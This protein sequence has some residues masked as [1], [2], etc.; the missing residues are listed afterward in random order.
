MQRD[1]Y[2]WNLHPALLYG[3][4]LLSG[5]YFA[6]YSPWALLP[7]LLL[8]TTAPSRWPSLTLCFILPLPWL[9]WS[10]AP[11]QGRLHV[12][13]VTYQQG[14]LYRGTLGQRPVILRS[15]VHHPASCDY[16][17][18][19]KW[20]SPS[21][22]EAEEW[23]PLGRPSLAEKRYRI[24][25]VITEWF[26]AHSRDP[27][28]ARFL[29]SLATGGMQ[30]CELKKKCQQLGVGHLLAVSGIHFSL[31]YFCIYRLSI[32]CLPR[33]GAL[34]VAWCIISCYGLLIGHTPSVLRAWI[35]ITAYLWGEWQERTQSA[36]NRL[37]LALLGSLI[38]FP[39]DCQTLSFQFSFLA[40]GAI[41]L[42]LPLLA[43]FRSQYK[44]IK[45]LC[46]LTLAI[47]I[48]MFPLTC[49]HF[50]LFYPHSFF[51]NLFIPS[52]ALGGLVL[53]PI[54]PLADLYTHYVVTFLLHPPWV[55]M[56]IP[57]TMSPGMLTCLTT[58]FVF[59]GLVY[60]ERRYSSPFVLRSV[61]AL[62]RR[63]HH[64]RRIAA[65]SFHG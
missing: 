39:F 42:T 1:W 61:G 12:D 36:L 7:F 15:S 53:L 19:G 46:T 28:A 49:F 22:F 41:L 59:L 11:N 24:K 48:V 38:F 10:P 20:V 9:F 62:Q 44:Y 37:G 14:W 6:L 30:A 5:W 21:R 43:S 17:V 26:Y 64:I 27:E 16:F 32:W 23:I 3:M 45:N 13:H 34:C 18:K 52:L 2:Q 65:D 8:G 47:Q 57:C 60:Q 63:M 4:V 31:L 58:G 25:A 50:H 40:T 55:M 56:P 35:F 33:K 51:Y 54:Y 29:S